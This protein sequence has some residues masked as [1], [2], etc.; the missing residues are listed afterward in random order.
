MT[1]KILTLDIERLCGLAPIFDQK[2]RFIHVSRWRRLPRTICFAANWYDQKNVQFYAE[3]QE[4][5]HRAMIE[6]AWRLL[7]EAD[8]VVTFNGRAFDLKHLREG[9]VEY[10]LGEPSPWKDVDLYLAAR[11]RLGYESRS[12]DHLCQ[13][14]GIP[15]KRGHYDDMQAE[16]ACDGDPAAQRAIAAY[17]RQDVRATKGC[18]DR[19]LPHLSTHPN[20]ALYVEDSDGEGLCPKCPDPQPDTLVKRG[21][22]PLGVSVFQRYWCKACKSWSR[23]KTAIGRAEMRPVA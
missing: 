13:R 5:G 22:Y 6:Q 14:L 1:A 9:F 11:N 4:G 23:G 8:I 7:D 10:Q 15:G 17:N 3:W 20:M 18:Y 19:L 21:P 12:L 2:V 16:D